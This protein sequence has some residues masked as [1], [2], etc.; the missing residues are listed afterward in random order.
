MKLLDLTNH[1]YGMLTVL[2]ETTKRYDRMWV[3]KCR[4]GVIIPASER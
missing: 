4:C 1:T 2:Y 3:C